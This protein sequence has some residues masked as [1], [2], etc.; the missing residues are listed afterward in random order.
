[1]NFNVSINLTAE[2]KAKII[3]C[4]AVVN[5]VHYILY[6]SGFNCIKYELLNGSAKGNL[7]IHALD[8]CSNILYGLLGMKEVSK[9]DPKS[10]V[11]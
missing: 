11:K 3:D 9:E 10:I 6:K 7:S 8:T 2:E 5:D 4:L 1:M